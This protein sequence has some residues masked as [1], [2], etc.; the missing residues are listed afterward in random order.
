[1]V[2]HVRTLLL[3][4]DG[5]AV[6]PDWTLGDEAVP[7]DYRAVVL[8]NAV[9]Q[10]RRCLFGENPDQSFIN[11]RL[12]QMLTVIHA[13]ELDSMVR[14]PDPRI[15]YL[16]IRDWQL[17]PTAYYTPTAVVAGTQAVELPHI[18]PGDPPAVPDASGRM[19]HDYRI[20]LDGGDVATTQFSPAY[21]TQ[22]EVVTFADGWSAQLLALGDSGHSFYVPDV[23]TAAWQVTFNN[24]PQWDL[25]QVLATIE[26]IGEPILLGL[27]G[28]GGAGSPEP[29]GTFRNLF[30]DR[31]EL[32]YRLGAVA[33]A[34][35]W[36][37]DAVRLQARQEGAA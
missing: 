25:G 17:F 36:R 7:V 15:T 21:D 20:E 34:M 16:P 29:Y 28:T 37:T 5:N 4:R 19:Y 1:M 11:F 9:Q 26:V 35:A 12:A 2:N 13:S 6:V 8:P 27:F 24:R 30:Y 18:V 33:L 14:W 3:N 23:G 32:P 31:R 10:V 22:A